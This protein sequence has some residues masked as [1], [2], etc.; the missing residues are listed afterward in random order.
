LNVLKELGWDTSENDER[1]DIYQK[2]EK[3]VNDIKNINQNITTVK[4]QNEST[5]ETAQDAY[6]AA[7]ENEQ[8]LAN[9]TL[10]AATI[11]ATGIGG[12]ELARGLSEQKADKAAEQDMAAYI[13]TF[14]C[15]YGNGKQVKAGPDEI[16]LPGGNDETFMK[17]RSEYMALAADL[18][19]RKLALG[20]KPGIESEEILDKS[21]MGL[22]DDENIGI[23]SGAYSSLYRAQMLNSEEDQAKIDED[24]KKSKARVIGGGIAA[25]V[26]V[27][28]GAIGNALINGDL[29]NLI[30][31]NKGKGL[32]SEN[33]AV[34][35]KFKEKLKSIGMTNVDKLN[36]NNIDITSMSDAIDGTDFSG[37]SSLLQGKDATKLL[38]TSSKDN[39][40]KSLGGALGITK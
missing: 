37:Y 39:F 40:I 15:E 2:L 21:Q 24:A 30:K 1:K 20:M 26:G 14:R 28:G 38:N 18:K 23:E 4:S 32:S 36:F 34:I 19:E 9:R 25:G 5:S 35:N 8:S 27:V 16:E 22:Y 3:L 33:K 10:T 11:A 31:D 29:G 17:L 6:E 12:M 13:E 7:K